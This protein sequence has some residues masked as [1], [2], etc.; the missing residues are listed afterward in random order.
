MIY[1]AQASV[2]IPEVAQGLTA[3]DV[4]PTAAG[5]NSHMARVVCGLVW[6]AFGAL[7]AA[8]NTVTPLCW[9]APTDYAGPPIPNSPAAQEAAYVHALVHRWEG[10]HDGEFGSGFSNANYWYRATGHHQ[11]MGQLQAAALKEAGGDEALARYVGGTRL[12]PTRLVQLCADA[13]RPGAEPKVRA[14]AERVVNLEWRLLFDWCYA[15][16]A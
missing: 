7:D 3:A 16:L 14:F 5:A 15:R 11:V 10:S 8:H 9:G 1:S 12:D 6:V 13:Q 4:A 2:P